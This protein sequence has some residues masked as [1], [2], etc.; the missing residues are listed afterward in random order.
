MLWKHP[1]ISRDNSCQR[2]GLLAGPAFGVHPRRQRSLDPGPGLFGYP[3]HPRVSLFLQPVKGR[4]LGG[5]AVIFHP[6][7]DS[8]VI[9]GGEVPFGQKVIYLRRTAGQVGVDGDENCG[10]FEGAGLI[11]EPALIAVGSFLQQDQ[12]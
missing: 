10:V 2:D 11:G 5:S 8:L 12:V 7:E 3:R 6:L 4:L 9:C 1:L